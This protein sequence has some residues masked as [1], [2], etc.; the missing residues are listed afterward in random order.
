MLLT[1]N[2]VQNISQ[3][4]EKEGVKLHFYEKGEEIPLVKQGVWQVYSGMVQ[5]SMFNPSEKEVL[6][7]W[8]QPSTFFGRWLA[9]TD[10]YQAK[11]LSDTYLRWY[12]PKEIEAS[13]S[14]M[15][16]MLSQTI[17]RI[18]QT[19]TLLAI[20][21]IRRVEDRLLHLFLLLKEEMGE[22][23]EGGTRLKVRLTHQNIANAIGTTRVTV[24][25]LIGDFQ[26]QG[27]ITIDSDR[28]IVVLD[29][30]N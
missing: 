16:T 24:T 8:A 15:R 1:Y 23:V 28:Q 20:A 26:R 18:R 19:E 29:S 11:S 2:A 5:L 30:H 12:S 17:S 13:S 21:T 27:N 4:E 22:P 3:N 9:S 6:L 7:G 25:R 14:L 10:T